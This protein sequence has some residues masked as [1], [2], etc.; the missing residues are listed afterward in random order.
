MLSRGKA[1]GV[2][3]TFPADLPGEPCGS[4]KAVVMEEEALAACR[5]MSN[6][7]NCLCCVLVWQGS[8]P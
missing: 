2:K 4:D 1:I 8:L 7:K 3:W 6:T 5:V